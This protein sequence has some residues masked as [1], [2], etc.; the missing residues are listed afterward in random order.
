MNTSSFIS[1]DGKALAA[2]LKNE[3]QLYLDLILNEHKS[4]RPKLCVILVGGL[5]ASTTYVQAKKIACE[6]V[7]VEADIIQLE[8]TSSEKEII[9]TIEKLNNDPS[10]H[11][12]LVQLP[13]PRSINSTLVLET[14]DPLK[15]VDGLHSVNAGRLVTGDQRAMIPCTPKGIV[16]LLKHYNIQTS[17]KH[18]VIIGRSSIVGRPLSILMSHN[19]WKGD[20]TVTLLHSKSQNIIDH[21]KQADILICAAGQCQFITKEFIK[22]GACVVDVGIHRLENGK[23][24]G[25]VEATSVQEIAGALSP[26]PGGVG[27]MTVAM[28]VENVLTAWARRNHFKEPS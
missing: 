27:P 17:A 9:Q 25:D 5:A 10:V 14:I 18:V 12:I 23:L 3:Q 24:C 6:K 7:G 13:L 28:V 21:T 15:D 26:V 4:Q 19:Q 11:G 16:R 20:S 1:L 22:T 2:V 8:A